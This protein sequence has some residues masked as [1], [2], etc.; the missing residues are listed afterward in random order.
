MAWH[1]AYRAF[2]FLVLIAATAC[3]GHEPLAPLFMVVGAPTSLTATALSFS[4]IS[5]SWQDNSNSPNESGFEVHRSGTGPTGTFALIGTAGPQGTS[6]LDAGLIGLTQYCYKIRAYRTTGHKTTYSDFSA[7]ACA[8]TPRA[9][10]PAAP[11]GVTAAPYYGYAFHVTWADNSTDESGFRIERSASA[12]GTWSTVVKVDPNTT[13]LIDYQV[14]LEQ[15]ACYRVF[16][17]NSYGDSDPSNVVC[18]AVPAAPSDLAATVTGTDVNLLWT[19]N[20]NVEDGFDVQRAVEGGIYSA[21][22]HADANATS[23]HDASLSPDIIYSYFVRATKNGGTSGSSNT[24]KA[25][26]ATAAPQA[27]SGLSAYP[28]GS[29][30][31]SLYWADGSNN[32]QGFRVERS[33]GGGAWVPLGNSGMDQLSFVDI[34]AEPEQESCYRVIAFNNAGEAAAPDNPCVT[35]LA[36]PTDLRATAIDDYTVDFT[37][38]DNSA[39]EDGY[40]LWID[41]GYYGQYPVADVPAGNGTGTISFQ[42]TGYYAYGYWF[43]VVA[44]KNGVYSDF[45]WTF[46][47]PPAGVARVGGAPPKAFH[48]P[49]QR[50]LTGR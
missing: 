1:R 10:V 8:T 3:N 24:T 29:H 25:I 27:P 23:F 33:T 15:P 12:D 6:Y 45:V 40:Q 9:P 17:T 37:W 20:S 36:A 22:G 49:R 30:I 28:S 41:D 47:A 13:S 50:K 16:A 18:T 26:L 14:V 21:I 44:V 34:S 46:A 32:E 38:T 2:P 19:D 39:I 11:S 42:L 31:V 4:Q 7:V 48:P 35:T 43:G 5:L